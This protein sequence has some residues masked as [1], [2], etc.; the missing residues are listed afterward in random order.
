M[1]RFSFLGTSH[2]GFI[3][4]LYKEYLSDPDS[5]EPSWRAF[6]Q[7][8]DFSKSDFSDL[9]EDQTVLPDEVRKEFSVLNLVHGYR[10][11][12]HLFTQTNPVRTRRKYSPDLSLKNFGLNDSD[13]ELKFQAASELG[14]ESPAS[15]RDIINHLENT[16]CRS[17][18][19][20]YM[21]V[22]EPDVISWIQKF[23]QSNENAPILDSNDRLYILHKLNEAIAFESFLNTKFVGQKRFSIEGAENLIPGLDFLL[24]KAAEIGVEEVVL[25]MAHRGRLNVLTNL[26]GKP[27]SEIFSEFEGKQFEE[28]DFDG[29]VKYH[30]GY[31]AERE[32]DNGKKLKLNIA[33]NPSHLEAVDP[34]VAGISR[35]KSRSSYPEDPSKVLPIMIHGDAAI[36]GQGV[37][38]EVIQMERLSGYGT[39]G[40]IHV[41]INNQVGFTTNFID[42]RSS[43]YCTDVAKVVLAPVLHVNG[44][45]T[46]AVI[47]AMR[48]AIEYRQ[49]WKRDVFIDLLCY[50]KYGHNE[51]DEP[52]F[53]QPLLYKTISKHPN[54]RKIYFDKLLATGEV[55]SNL[56]REMESEFKSMLEGL[57]DDSKKIEKNKIVPF[58]LDEWNDYPRAKKI[59]IHNIPDTSISKDR[60]S[61]VAKTLTALPPGKKFFKKITR[62]IG[63]RK[64]MAF[65]KNALDWGMAEM[66][67]YGTLLQDGFNIRISGEDVERGTFSHRHAIIK[68]EDSE[69]E[70]CLLDNIPE[71]KGRFAIY[72]S[73]LSE[74]AVLGFD[75]GYAMASP[76]TLVIWEAQFGD[77]SNGAQ[78]IIDQFIAAAED[79]WKVQNGLVLLL[80]H[81]YEGQGAEHSSARLERFL[82]LCAQQNMFVCN[83]TTPANHFHLLRRQ[84][85]QKFRKPLV[86]M[87]PKSLLR[88][89]LAVSKMEELG[90]GK[91][92]PVIPDFID[93]RKVKKVVFCS[94]KIYYELLEE[95]NRL[96]NEETAIIRLEQLYPLP[97]KEMDRQLSKYNKKVKLIWTQEEPANMGAWSYLR[98]K[99]DYPFECISPKVSAS[100]AP[101]SKQAAEQVQKKLI[102]Q[103]FES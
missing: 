63:D 79:K 46:E 78:I 69:E 27:A 33:P 87:S 56:I 26:F 92:L 44:D 24:Q 50:R 76:D 75:Y 7:G 35:A 99:T 71:S 82:Q 47:H 45:D 30:L 43:T 57:F 9:L 8:Y 4:D 12:G 39:E 66:M 23:I 36:S 70:V 93:E 25:G 88:H 31:T 34:I 94:G 41:V 73:H 100:T 77:F 54:P 98:V 85:L 42:G 10:T 90:E 40:T 91:F 32:L 53:T 52:R 64:K 22:R 101:G 16:Y 49:K 103:T 95:R 17:I 48:F 59:D 1:D 29:D 51:G 68:I 37:V 20:E 86:I 18:G 21:Y 5:I 61:S 28:A 80:P 11:R 38:Y 83:P 58:M 2:I 14:L 6:F 84:M 102:I 55:D 15:L 3:E 65:E 74:Y 97:K 67:A 19:V 89:P 62:L 13:L 96:N 81:G 60:L 72:N